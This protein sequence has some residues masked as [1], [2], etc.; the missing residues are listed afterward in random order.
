MTSTQPTPDRVAM[1]SGDCSLPDHIGPFVGRIE[2]WKHVDGVAYQW[3]FVVVD[4]HF[5]A[6][7]GMGVSEHIIPLNSDPY[8]FALQHALE[9]IRRYRINRRRVYHQVTAHWE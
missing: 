3:R 9:G 7:R 5:L 8:E 1:V 6:L 2:F 4:G